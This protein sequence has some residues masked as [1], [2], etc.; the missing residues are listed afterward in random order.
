MEVKA[1]AK[2][3]RISADK[4]R[5]VMNLIRGKDV[6]GA[7]AILSNLNN[8]ASKVIIKVLDSA[9]ANAL[10]NHKLNEEKLYISKAYV[11]EGSIIKRG[12]FD[13]RGHIGR[14][15]HRTSHLTVMVSE[16]D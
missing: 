1:V 3:V 14:N 7:H 12:M 4:A 6:V 11:D 5:L 2:D 13:S 9:K 8:R 15:D 16:R 10:N